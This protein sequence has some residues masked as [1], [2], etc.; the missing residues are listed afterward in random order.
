VT[1]P[2]TTEPVE[3]VCIASVFVS[4]SYDL[5]MNS[6]AVLFV[7]IRGLTDNSI[8]LSLFNLSFVFFFLV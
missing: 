5:S 7:L 6:C 1:S 3:S 2:T 4:V 8:V